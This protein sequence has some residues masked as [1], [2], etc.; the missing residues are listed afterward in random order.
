MYLSDIYTISVNLAGIGGISLPCGFAGGGL[1]IGLQLIAPAFEEGRLITAAHA[2]EQ[3]CDW[4]TRRPMVAAAHGAERPA[5]AQPHAGS[6]GVY[7]VASAKVR[8]SDIR[9]TRWA[10]TRWRPEMKSPDAPASSISASSASTRSMPA[11]FPPEVQGAAN[12]VFGQFQISAGACEGRARRGAP[13][14]RRR[15]SGGRAAPAQPGGQTAS[16]P[17]APDAARVGAS[18]GELGGFGERELGRKRLGLDANAGRHGRTRTASESPSARG[19]R[20]H[21]A[22]PGRALTRP[23]KRIPARRLV[24]HV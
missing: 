6:G 22:R 16:R 19:V 4:H 12:S 9:S 3:A 1:P 21:R 10:E 20:P 18:R 5:V 17:A 14:V 15:R 2:Y 8:V 11:P 13:R 24:L 7:A 23:M